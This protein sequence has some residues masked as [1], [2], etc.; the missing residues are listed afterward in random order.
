MYWSYSILYKSPENTGLWGRQSFTPSYATDATLV[1]L[2][3][4]SGVASSDTATA[5]QSY[6]G[7]RLYNLDQYEN[8]SIKL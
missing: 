2:N 5:V 1:S 3:Q 6:A 8:P 7:T 4:I